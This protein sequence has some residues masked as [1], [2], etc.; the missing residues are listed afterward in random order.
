[1]PL[2]PRLGLA[3]VELLQ[4]L[5]HRRLDVADDVVAEPQPNEKAQEQRRDRLEQR[6]AQFLKMLAERHL[7][8]LKSR[9]VVVNGHG[10][11]KTRSKDAN[12]IASRAVPGPGET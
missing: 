8:L 3:E 10:I 9:F 6:L 2:L 7:R 12:S 1:V 11:T 4:R 5:Q